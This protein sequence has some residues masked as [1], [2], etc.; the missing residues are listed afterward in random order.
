M[1]IRV[2]SGEFRVFGVSDLCKQGLLGFFGVKNVEG[3]QRVSGDVELIASVPFQLT[4][5]SEQV[6][7]GKGFAWTLS[8]FDIDRFGECVF[9]QHLNTNYET[10]EHS[11]QNT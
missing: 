5:N 6:T 2:K 7:E 3:V 4:V 10:L 11:T 9:R 8:T 1:V